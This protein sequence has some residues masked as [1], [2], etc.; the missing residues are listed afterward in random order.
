M[1]GW[2]TPKER[3]F[4]ML[5]HFYEHGF[6]QI[7]TATNYPINKQPEDFRKSEN[8]LSEWIKT[9]GIKDLK[10]IVKVGSINNLRSSVHNLSKSFLLMN[11]D[12][13][14][15]KYGSNFNTFMIHWD[16]RDSEVEIRAT[17]EA[18]DKARAVGLEIGLSGILHPPLYKAFNTT[19]DFDFHIQ[20]KHNLLQS[21]YLRYQVFHGKRCFTTYG[22]NGGGIKLDVDDY[23]G[24]SSLQARGGNI[25]IEH[26][27]TLSLRQVLVQVNLLEPRP[28]L[29]TMNQIGMLYAYYSPD[30]ESILIGPSNLSQLKDTLAFY[31]QLQSYDYTDVFKKLGELTPDR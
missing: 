31:T 5:N 22:I 17:L 16:N 15:Y 11:L 7:D 4:E 2:T 12:D 13:Y 28:K 20:I 18:L 6:R 21:D 10:I 26:P 9:Q 3:C 8:I 30:I 23:N 27:I 14:Q 19:F 29:H 25:A 24:Q 1:W